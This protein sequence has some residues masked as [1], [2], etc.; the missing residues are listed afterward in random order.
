MTYFVV[1]PLSLLPACV[2]Q[3][4]LTFR[5]KR[6]RIAGSQRRGR[7]RAPSLYAIWNGRDRERAGEARFLPNS[8]S[9]LC[10]RLT[11]DRPRYRCFA[12]DAKE[13]NE[14]EAMMMAAIRLNYDRGGTARCAAGGR[15]GRPNH[16]GQ[17]R[18]GGGGG[19]SS[20]TN[21]L[22]MPKAKKAGGR[23]R[24]G[25]RRECNGIAGGMNAEPVHPINVNSG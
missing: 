6:E 3:L 8:V 24:C 19:R 1:L 2:I 17:G 12:L 16:L 20:P 15:E 7:R 9:L 11:D 18:E 10:P 13:E 21:D 4:P 14:E 25:M 22:Q 23:R 5:G